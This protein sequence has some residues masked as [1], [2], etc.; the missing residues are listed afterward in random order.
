MPPELV[1]STIT[2]FADERI[3]VISQQVMTRAVLLQLVDKY[4][5]YEKYRGRANSEE[6]LEQMRRDIKL[7][8]V[9]ADISD[10]SSGRRVNATIAFKISYD[11]PQPDSAQ[12]VVND[13]VS[14]YLNENIKARQQSV[15]ETTAFLTQ[16]SDRLAMQI[17]EIETNLAAFKRRHVGRMPDSSRG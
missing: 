2:S 13:L 16:E 4:G 15:A 6:I 5:L 3:Q 12:R 11:A 9:N 17:K 14:L 8:T 1:R 10:R 7:S